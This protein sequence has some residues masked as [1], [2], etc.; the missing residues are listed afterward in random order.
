MT[1]YVPKQKK[2][3]LAVRKWLINGDLTRIA[4]ITG[5]SQIYVW[6]CFQG[7]RQNEAILRE[8]L[9]IAKENKA[10]GLQSPAYS[11]ETETVTN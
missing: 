3:F 10:L 11:A 6:Q 7:Q 2:R 8:G 9:R 5:Y 1:K 4:K